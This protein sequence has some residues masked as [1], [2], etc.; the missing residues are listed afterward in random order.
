MKKIVQLIISTLLF[1]SLVACGG[2]PQET[3]EEAV[4]DAAGKKYLTYESTGWEIVNE[5]TQEHENEEYEVYE[6]RVTYSLPQIE[7]EKLK[8]AGYRDFMGNE[9]DKQII[10]KGRLF[11]IKRGDAWYSSHQD[12]N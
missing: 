6:Y 9:F 3:L 10:R 7:I 2:V 11:F 12:M 1:S 4:F 8:Q 5:Y